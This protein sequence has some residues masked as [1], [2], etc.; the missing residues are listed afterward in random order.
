MYCICTYLITVVLYCTTVQCNIN[1]HWTTD[2]QHVIQVLVVDIIIHHTYEKE[3]LTYF[4][5]NHNQKQ[6]LADYCQYYNIIFDYHYVFDYVNLVTST[7]LLYCCQDEGTAFA[8]K[9]KSIRGVSL[10][11]LLICASLKQNVESFRI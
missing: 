8:E 1:H 7:S 4:L 3:S 2:I 5:G 10:V 11:S 6:Y 9:K